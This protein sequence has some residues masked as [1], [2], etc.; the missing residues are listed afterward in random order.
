MCAC[1][2]VCVKHLP[3]IRFVAVENFSELR[4]VERL[5]VIRVSRNVSYQNEEEETTGEDLLRHKTRKH[6]R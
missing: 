4:V 5:M 1:V 6:K 2:C 3:I